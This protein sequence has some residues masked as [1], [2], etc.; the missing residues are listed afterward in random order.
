MRLE[1][2]FATATVARA[3]PAGAMPRNT[4]ENPS[5]RVGPAGQA[6]ARGGDWTAAVACSNRTETR[7]ETPDSSIVTP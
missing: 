1:P 6:A 3:A 7:F 2:F 4:G 5:F